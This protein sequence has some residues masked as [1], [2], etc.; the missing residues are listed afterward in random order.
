MP[1]AVAAIKKLG[2]TVRDNTSGEVIQV[3][4]SGTKITDKG[5]EHLKG[6]T[7]LTFLHLRNT[8]VTDAGLEYLKGIT[9][10]ISL[11]L[12]GTKITDAGLAELKA[13]L[14]KCRVSK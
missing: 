2:G 9:S 3:T 1:K 12:P 4:L 8:N 7:S 5:L 11:N 10:L 14:P 6:L 13:A